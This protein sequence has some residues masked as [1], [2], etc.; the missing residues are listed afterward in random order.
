MEPDCRLSDDCLDGCHERARLAD[1]VAPRAVGRSRRRR[2]GQQRASRG[3]GL[4]NPHSS[5]LDSNS[6]VAG[7]G[8]LRGETKCSWPT[9]RMQAQINRK[10]GGRG[11]TTCE[12]L[13]ANAPG[14]LP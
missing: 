5:S 3:V 10:T 13:A 11:G 8:L 1:G 14:A 6:D 7:L 4:G 2:R 12:A 9:L